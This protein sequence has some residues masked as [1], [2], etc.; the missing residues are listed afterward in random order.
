M[1]TMYIVYDLSSDVVALPLLSYAIS[2]L[3]VLFNIGTKM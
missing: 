3:T 2:P 1:L